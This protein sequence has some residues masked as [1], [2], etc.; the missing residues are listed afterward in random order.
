MTAKPGVAENSSKGINEAFGKQE[1]QVIASTT[2]DLLPMRNKTSSVPLMDG[3][4]LG[5]IIQDSGKIDDSKAKPQTGTQAAARKE[6]I[7]QKKA[8]DER[9]KL[10][11]WVR[12]FS[13][14]GEIF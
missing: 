13:F 3:D 5:T 6:G 2:A 9:E 8:N 11:P 12:H 1:K 10:K 14:L 4:L 7:S